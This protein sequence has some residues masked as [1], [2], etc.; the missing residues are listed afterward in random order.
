MN[1]VIRH[2]I[3]LLV[4]IKR[5]VRTI[6]MLFEHEGPLSLDCFMRWNCSCTRRS[7]HTVEMPAITHCAFLGSQCE[8]NGPAKGNCSEG[9]AG[10]ASS[11]EKLL[12]DPLGLHTFAVSDQIA[13]SVGKT[14]TVT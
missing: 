9:P 3:H 14:K 13:D 11:F 8:E 5:L 6:D 10:W 2:G 4:P 1:V 12:E 7:F